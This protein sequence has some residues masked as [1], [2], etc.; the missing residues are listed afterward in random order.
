[1]AVWLTWGMKLYVRLRVDELDRLLRLARAE[2]RSPQDQAAH[3]L[4]QALGAAPPAEPRMP[5]SGTLPSRGAM[6]ATGAMG[7]DDG[8]AG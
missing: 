5:P 3:L 8:R 2:R 1:V 6:P 4:A 7:T